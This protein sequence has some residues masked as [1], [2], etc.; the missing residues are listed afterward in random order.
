MRHL[1]FLNRSRRSVSCETDVGHNVVVNEA[2]LRKWIIDSTLS[3][4]VLRTA[5]F[6]ETEKPQNCIFL[7]RQKN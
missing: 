1:T 3:G 4:V 2:A 7:L 5:D 6:W